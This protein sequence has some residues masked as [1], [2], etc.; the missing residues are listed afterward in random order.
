MAKAEITVDVLNM[1]AVRTLAADN[2]RL[3]EA[4][5]AALAVCEV[6]ANMTCTCEGYYRC[7]GCESRVSQQAEDTADLIREALATAVT[8][9]AESDTDG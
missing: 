4:L 6:A 7:N 2:A 5:E 1:S 9:P 3:R 8:P